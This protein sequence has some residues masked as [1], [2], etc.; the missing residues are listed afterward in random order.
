ML[1]RSIPFYNTILKCAEYADSQAALDEGYRLRLYQPGDEK[2]WAKLHVETGDFDSLGEAEAYFLSTYCMDVREAAQRCVFAVDEGGE[3]AGSCI[4]WRDRRGEETVASLHWLVVSSAHQGKGLGKA[5]CRQVMRIF[6][7]K[8]EMPVYIHTQ[9][10]SYSAI[11][12]YVRMGFRL[13]RTDTF[14]H[15]VNQYD[16]AMETLKALL[17][18]EQLDELLACSE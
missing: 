11:L 13:Q 12:L 7:S 9:P 17:T 16:Q 8:G 3:I 2:G 5:L 14:A 6:V 18:R 10:W 15:Y 1:D 4:A